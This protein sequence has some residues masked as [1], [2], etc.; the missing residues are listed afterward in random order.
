[1]LG[2]RDPDR[3]G[4]QAEL[5]HERLLARQ[6]RTHGTLRFAV[7]ALIFAGTLVAHW[8]VGIEELR[9]EALFAIAIVIATVNLGVVAAVR[10]LGRTSAES[11]GAARVALLKLRHVTMV[12]DYLSLTVLVLLVGGARS[13]FT[14]V[15]L[16]HV[17]LGAVMVSRSAAWIYTAFAIALINGL[18]LGELVGWIQPDMPVGAVLDRSP[19]TPRFAAT[20]LVAYVFLFLVTTFL[21][22]QLADSL[23]RADRELISAKSQLEHLSAARRDFLHVALHNLKSPIAAVSMLVENVRHGLAGPVTEKQR[24]LLT[25]VLERLRDSQ[26]FMTDLNKLAQ[27]EAADLGSLVET[28]P[29]APMLR[30]IIDE[31]RDLSDQRRQ[32]LQLQTD[33]SAELRVQGSERLLHEATVNLVTNAIKFTPREGQITV[34][35]KAEGGQVHIWV[36]DTGPGIL[37]EQQS[38]LFLEFARLDT[39]LPDGERPKGSGLGLSIVKRITE[40]HGGTVSVQS[41]AGEGTTFSLSFP[42]APPGAAAPPSPPE[43]LP[44]SGAGS[45]ESDTQVSLSADHDNLPANP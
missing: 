13:P 10:R 15:F 37:P 11:P 14:V 9:H 12:A 3:R 21:M 44:P 23:R 35:A 4:D 5:P 30:R 1:M 24:E 6:M 39:Q 43:S 26:D 41:T 33:E 27:L 18:V 22:T 34:G 31:H 19:L 42:I 45:A 38:K 25:R 7:A 17:V 36:R 29:I 2:L 16:L 20:L 28:V 32:T 8:V 40:A